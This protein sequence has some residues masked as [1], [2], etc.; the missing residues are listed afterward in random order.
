MASGPRIRQDPRNF[1]L[2]PVTVEVP[3]LQVGAGLADYEDLG[4]YVGALRNPRGLHMTLL[5]LGVAEELS[6]DVARW[7]KDVTGSELVLRR[8]ASWLDELPVLDA[9]SG[10]SQRLIA[11]GGGG[12][13]GLDVDVPQHVFEYQVSLVQALHELL[14]DLLVDNIDDFILSSPA[15]GFR[16]PRW[17]PHVAIGRPKDRERGPWE[18]SS[19]PL[20]FGASRIRNRQTLPPAPTG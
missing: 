3:L 6:Q 4:R 7:T 1:G 8:V 10:S 17:L 5:H 18:I 2:P 9:F 14:D 20:E 16:S 19:L 12:V 11:L 15:L 13:S